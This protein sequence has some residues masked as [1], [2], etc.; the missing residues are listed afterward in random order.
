MD[1]RDGAVAHHVEVVELVEEP[2]RRQLDRRREAHEGVD[3]G[4]ELVVFPPRHQNVDVV[5]PQD[6]GRGRGQR[7]VVAAALRL[8]PQ[9]RGADDP[10]TLLVRHVARREGPDHVLVA[11]EED[12]PRCDPARGGAARHHLH[13][14][15]PDAEQ[16][17]VADREDAD[18]STAREDVR[19]LGQEGQDESPEDRDAPEPER[20]FG[21]ALVRQVARDGVIVPHDSGNDEQRR[22]HGREDEIV[23]GAETV[24]E[25]P[26]IRAAVTRMVAPSSPAATSRK[27]IRTR[28]VWVLPRPAVRPKNRR[29]RR[30]R[31]AGP[32]SVV[33]GDTANPSTRRIHPKLPG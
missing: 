17:Q 4:F 18:R 31:S 8:R 14:G 25:D 11:H 26:P 15:G 21:M 10:Q 16:A 27:P 1:G 20:A 32:W 30:W 22:R 6:A 19:R 7:Q 5:R 28:I 9:H 12:V 24:F 3:A 13:Q 2:L 33:L 29:T 23:D